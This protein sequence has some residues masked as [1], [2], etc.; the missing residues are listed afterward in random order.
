[1]NWWKKPIPFIYILD[2]LLLGFLCTTRYYITPQRYFWGWYGRMGILEPLFL[3]SLFFISLL[4]LF[5]LYGGYKS[6]K[7]SVVK[8]KQMLYIFWAI[9]IYVFSSV[10]FLPTLGICIY[11][12]G[13]IFNIT[14]IVIVAMAIIRYRAME[15]DTVV[16][17]TILWLLTSLWLVAPSYI[18]FTVLRPW[19]REL[20][21]VGLTMFALLFF[22]FFMSYYRYF[23]PK[24]DHAFRRRKYDY[25]T[26]LGKVA[27]KIA[28]TISIEDLTGQLLNEVCEAMYLRNSLLYVLIK[29]KAKYSLI[30]RRG[31]KESEGIK[32]PAALDIYAEADKTGPVGMQHELS[33]SNPIFAWLAEHRNVLEKEQ[34]EVDPKYEGIKQHALAFFNENNIEVVVPLV[35][36]DS[37][38]AVLGLGKKDNLQAYTTEDL[39]LLK[40][41]GQE[42][43]VTIF[44]ALHYEDLADKERLDEEMR[45]GH[46]IQMTLLPSHIPQVAG[47]SVQGLMQPAKEIGGDYY[48]FIESPGKDNL[49]IVIGDVSGK[50]VAAGLLMAMAK[51][52]IHTLSQEETSPKQ[53]LMRTNNILYQHIGGQKFMTLLYLMW[54]PQSH[55]ILYSSAGHEHILLCRTTA[56]IVEAIP[57]GGFMLGMMADIDDFLEE[58][59]FYLSP[60]DKVL[61]YTDGVTEALNKDGERFSLSRLKEA[62]REHS[63]KPVKELM[64]AIKDDVYTFIGAHAQYD[65]ITIVAMEAL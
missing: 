14:F 40:K 46:Q 2:I 16:H 6:G 43:G 58:K 33:A 4:T 5:M 42:A 30:G 61:L 60:G 3:A 64:Q 13:F 55:S 29:E 20:S 53:I 34:L 19:I 25:Q 36:K 45:M 50:G 23:Q 52:A 15:I 63:Q 38:N 24:I 44:N 1:M 22:Y 21:N 32:Q 12:F 27:E 59:E 17:Q 7:Y 56:G 18:L 10:D 26:I 28:T 54:R 11:P 57:S 35:V 62:F 9:T 49:S 47:L 37:V 48:D 51:T 65:D 41:L 39:N 8:T 31:Y